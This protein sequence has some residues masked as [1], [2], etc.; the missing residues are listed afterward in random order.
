MDDALALVE[1]FYDPGRLSPKPR[2][3]LAHLMSG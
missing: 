3:L 1:R 2:L